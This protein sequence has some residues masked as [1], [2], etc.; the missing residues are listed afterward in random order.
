MM[1]PGQQA[2]A[3]VAPLGEISQHRLAGA[4][5]LARSRIERKMERPLAHMVEAVSR[6]PHGGGSL[7]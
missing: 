4:D 1:N 2:G 7:D 6:V 3:F 5:R